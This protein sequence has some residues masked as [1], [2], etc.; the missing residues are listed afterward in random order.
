MSATA[1]ELSAAAHRNGFRS[2]LLLRQRHRIVGLNGAKMPAGLA[3]QIHAWRS[4][5]HGIWGVCPSIGPSNSW[6]TAAALGRRSGQAAALVRRTMASADRSCWDCRRA[7]ARSESTHADQSKTAI[8]ARAVQQE[9]RPEWIHRLVAH[10]S[11]VPGV[12][13]HHRT[14]GNLYTRL[15]FR[16]VC[17]AACAAEMS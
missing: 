9:L 3:C 13:A 11:F 16:G 15:E 12:D 5:C 1:H 14:A 6:R 2:A 8:E 10:Q 7:R 17:P 4:Q